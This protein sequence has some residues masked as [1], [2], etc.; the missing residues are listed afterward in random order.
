MTTGQ[1]AAEA[2]QAIRKACVRI[3]SAAAIGLIF[4]GMIIPT[5]ASA[6]EC[7]DTWVGSAE[8]TWATAADWSTGKA[9]T[10]TTVACIGS[11]KKVNVTSGPVEVGMVE[12]EGSLGL[13][14]TL[15]LKGTSE[16]SVIGGL[17]MFFGS[18]LRGPGTLDISGSLN[19]KEDAY[20]RGAG[21]TVILPGAMATTAEMTGSYE[22]I[23]GRRFVNE[24]TLTAAA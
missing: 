8:G 7:T 3:L 22:R 14:N 2:F 9:P 1:P 24:G 10:A 16:A 6:A 23:E 19:W 20:M 17:T 21:S 12:G 5:S 13:S 15:E 18:V 11:G 4:V